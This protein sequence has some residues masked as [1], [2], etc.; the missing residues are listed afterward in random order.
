MTYELQPI[1]CVV[2]TRPEAIKMA[3]VIQALRAAPW[4]QCRVLFTA[5]HRDL[6]A[7]VLEYFGIRPDVDLDVMRAGQSLADLGNRLLVRL[8]DALQRERGALVLAQGDTVSVAAAAMASFILGMPFG[9]VEAGLRTHRLDAPFPEEANRVLAS[10]LATVH[11]A[12]TAAARANLIR[13]GIPASAIHVTGNTVIDALVMAAR[14]GDPLPLELGPGNRLVLVTLHRREN[15]GAPTRRVCEA[16]RILHDRFQDI[17][18]LWPVHPNPRIRPVIETALRGLPRV[19]LCDPLG[20]GPF[21]AALK[22]STLVL[23]DS[24]GVQ[25]EAPALGKPTLVL[26]ESSERTESIGW[27]TSRLVGLDP[28]RI[29]AAA[30]R[31]LEDEEERQRMCRVVNPY[32]DGNAAQRI[33]ATLQRLLPLRHEPLSVAG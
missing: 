30:S 18:L 1:V 28:Q 26:R 11:F 20:Y 27:G 4:A 33:V 17:E 13:E 10:H 32:G 29:V 6:A 7:P 2:G 8:H 24:G 21:V 31:L 14:Q 5:Q 9:H 16:I 19:R 23:T 3:P 15:L 25:E 22:A 12:P